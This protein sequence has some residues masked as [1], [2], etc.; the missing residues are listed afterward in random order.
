M[1]K[2]LS[3]KFFRRSAVVVAKDLLGCELSIHHGKNIVSGMIVET[4]AYLD[5]DPASHAFGG[6]RNRNQPMFLSGGY[7]YVYFI[8]GNHFCF[9]VVTGLEGVGEAVLIR[10]L[11]PL[12]GI[13]LMKRRRKK[14]NIHDLCSGPGKLC[15][16][17]GIN[18]D[19]NG[20]SI[21]RNPVMNVSRLKKF[22]STQIESSHRIGIRK[23]VEMPYRFSVVQSEFVSG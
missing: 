16:A 3:E 2:D 9:N 18:M 13:D 10:A 8:Y 17:L 4:E 14:S 5:D 20:Q 1:K 15:Q 23:A 11:E 12:N 22:R 6:K 7:V 21:L 19:I